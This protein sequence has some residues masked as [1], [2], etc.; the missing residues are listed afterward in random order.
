MNR[1]GKSSEDVIKALEKGIVVQ[2]EQSKFVV[3]PQALL[4]GLAA[5]YYSVH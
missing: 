2:K 1:V 4:G 3:I 5:R